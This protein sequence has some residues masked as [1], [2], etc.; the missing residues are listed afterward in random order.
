MHQHTLIA[1]M[2]GCGKTTLVRYLLSLTARAIVFD[3]EL[4]YDVPGAVT[5]DDL[6][7][8]M[9]AF[10]RLRFRD[11]ILIFRGENVEDF[12][13]LLDLVMH[14]QETE[15]L[16][17]I[18][19]VAE[20]ASLFSTTLK[21]DETVHRI[22]NRGRKRRVS[23]LTVIQMDSDI[24]RVSKANSKVIVCMQANQV[25][26]NFER[27]FKYE[28]IAGLHSVLENGVYTA[29]PVQGKHFLVYPPSVD[30]YAEWVRVFGFILKTEEA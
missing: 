18:L 29:K 30:L 13:L 4:E 28:Q 11:F 6:P 20:E 12:V 19:I 2:T 1:G 17:P 10:E 14:S 3:P 5:V 24:H 8:A 15:P 7:A 25:S 21:M 22:Y 27:Y 26:V 9:D 16:G 23:L